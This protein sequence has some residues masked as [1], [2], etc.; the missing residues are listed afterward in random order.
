[1]KEKVRHPNRP[2]KGRKQFEGGWK[3]T[4]AELPCSSNRSNPVP[5]A[6]GA[7]N[8]VTSSVEEHSRRHYVVSNCYVCTYVVVARFTCKIEL[9]EARTYLLFFSVSL[10]CN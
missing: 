3:K 10:I 9:I 8:S 1:M 4:P 6:S 7:K 5:R 2:C